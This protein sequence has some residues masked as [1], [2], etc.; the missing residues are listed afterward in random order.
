MYM[1]KDG[2][3]NVYMCVNVFIYIN[4]IGRPLQIIDHEHLYIYRSADEL[5][6]EVRKA[7]VRIKGPV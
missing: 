6:A 7:L 3:I 4:H 2:Y 5:E 1:D